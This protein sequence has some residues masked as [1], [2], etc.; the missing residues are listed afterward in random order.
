MTDESKQTDIKRQKT[1][2]LDMCSL[3][4]ERLCRKSDFTGAPQRVDQYLFHPRRTADQYSAW[5]PRARSM[6]SPQGVGMW[7]A[8]PWLPLHCRPSNWKGVQVGRKWAAWHNEA[9]ILGAVHL[10]PCTGNTS[11]LTSTQ[12]AWKRHQTCTVPAKK[13]RALAWNHHYLN[14]KFYG[15]VYSQDMKLVSWTESKF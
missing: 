6:C 10:S 3:A 4:L 8:R 1:A 5:S 7:K 12:A 9:V 14:F 13:L 11:T 2:L 15:L